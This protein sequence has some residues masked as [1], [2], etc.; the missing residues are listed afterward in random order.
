LFWSRRDL[1]DEGMMGIRLVSSSADGIEFFNFPPP[2]RHYSKK[3]SII[4]TIAAHHY[5]NFHSFPDVSIL[6]ES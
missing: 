3:M 4:T 1:V 5:R 2:P 6:K